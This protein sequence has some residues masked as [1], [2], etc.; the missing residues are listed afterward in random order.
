MAGNENF[1]IPFIGV[2]EMKEECY[3]SDRLLVVYDARTK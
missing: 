3:C 1:V 2:L